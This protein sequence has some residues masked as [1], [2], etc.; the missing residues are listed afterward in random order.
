VTATEARRFAYQ[1]VVTL[2]DFVDYVDQQKLVLDLTTPPA[3]S[4][5]LR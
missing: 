2:A 3:R 1:S 5:M 4:R